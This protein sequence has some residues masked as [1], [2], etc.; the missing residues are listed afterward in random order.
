[1]VNNS[2][3]SFSCLDTSFVSQPLHFEKG[4]NNIL[5]ESS[6]F[7]ITTPLTGAVRV[8]YGIAKCVFAAIEFCFKSRRENAT[9]RLREGSTQ[10]LKG[11]LEVIPIIG[12]I[13]VIILHENHNAKLGNEMTKLIK[14]NNVDEAIVLFD[15]FLPVPPGP[16]MMGHCPQGDESIFICNIYEEVFKTHPKEATEFAE[17][18][19]KTWKFRDAADDDELYLQPNYSKLFDILMETKDYQGAFQSV[20]LKINDKE[21]RISFLMK[22]YNESPESVTGEYL[23]E[24]N[25]NLKSK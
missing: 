1:M 6:V 19:P 18:S 22:L 14:K 24:V 16:K 15:R 4:F 12:A 17:K 23:D 25:D 3:K 13:A 21:E 11:C 2:I 8:V 5:N 20:I 9:I 7:F 10:V